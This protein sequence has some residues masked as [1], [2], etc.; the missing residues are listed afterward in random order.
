MLRNAGA[1]EGEEFPT[2]TALFSKNR[3]EDE[4]EDQDDLEES[5]MQ[6]NE[7][8]AENS[9][10]ET[11][12]LSKQKV[13]K[14]RASN[15]EEGAEVV[16][17]GKGSTVVFQH[18]GGN[19]G[20]QR[21]TA[22]VAKTASRIALYMMR[23]EMK[24]TPVESPVQHSHDFFVISSCGVAAKILSKEEHSE[25]EEEVVDFHG[26]KVDKQ[27][28]PGDYDANSAVMARYA[29]DPQG[30]ST[31]GTQLVQW[32]SSMVPLTLTSWDLVAEACLEEGWAEGDIAYLKDLVAFVNTFKVMISSLATILR[33]ELQS[34]AGARRQQSR[35]EG[36]EARAGKGKKAGGV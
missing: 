32:R 27:L 3:E 24:E 36:L 13:E 4:D 22:A 19:E 2:T 25:Q 20:D 6:D 7:G 23:E 11:S 10:L 16:G 35:C 33:I 12:R 15:D 31:R 26:L 21:S 18:G 30:R 1:G 28:L 17:D 34:L 9:Y 29:L 8:Q 5:F 14:E